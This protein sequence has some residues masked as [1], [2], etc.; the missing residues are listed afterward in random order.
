MPAASGAAKAIAET[1]LSPVSSIEDDADA[2]LAGHEGDPR[3]A[4]P[5]RSWPVTARRH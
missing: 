5:T 3:A 4:R 1:I 2:L